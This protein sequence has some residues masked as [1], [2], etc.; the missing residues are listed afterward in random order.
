[1]KMTLVHEGNNVRE[2]YARSLPPG[3]SVIEGTGSMQDS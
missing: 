2:G 1:M 3:A